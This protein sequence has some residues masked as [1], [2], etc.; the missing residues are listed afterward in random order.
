MLFCFTGIIM[1]EYN[2]YPSN[3]TMMNAMKYSLRIDKP[4]RLNYWYPSLENNVIIGIMKDG[5]KVLVNNSEYDFTSDIEEHYKSGDEFIVN[6]LDSIYIVSNKICA[7][8]ITHIHYPDD[9]PVKNTAIEPAINEPVIA[10]IIEPTAPN[11]DL[12]PNVVATIIEPTAPDYTLMQK[13][14]N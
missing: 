14:I 5:T 10:T 7:K 9:K 4:I 3:I 1:A 11:Y 8:R 6:T 2:R 13:T 12:I